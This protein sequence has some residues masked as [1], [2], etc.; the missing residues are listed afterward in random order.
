MSCF[1]SSLDK[2]KVKILNLFLR[3]QAANKA[4]WLNSSAFLLLWWLCLHMVVNLSNPIIILIPLISVS[5]FYSFYRLQDIR[6]ALNYTKSANS[7]NPIHE[8][9]HVP[10]NWRRSSTR[11]FSRF[12]MR[13]T[14]DY[15]WL[16]SRTLHTHTHVQEEPWCR[17]VRKHAFLSWRK[18]EKHPQISSLTLFIKLTKSPFIDQAAFE[19]SSPLAVLLLP[20]FYTKIRGC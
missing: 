3:L 13:L 20:P 18:N 8:P 17:Y 16:A 7:I 5:I 11:T 1:S 19:C 9:A 10:W 15:L 6:C 4:I 2:N 14:T 12:N